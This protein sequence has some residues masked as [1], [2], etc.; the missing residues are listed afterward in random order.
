MPNSQKSSCRVA[1]NRN[2]ATSTTNTQV[3]LS[4]YQA[5]NA[6]DVTVSANGD[7]AETADYLKSKI[8]SQS[9]SPAEAA[10]QRGMISYSNAAAARCSAVAE[11]LG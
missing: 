6:L 1:K 11:N 9:Q 7:A 2:T 5:A 3:L 4:R 10:S 8:T